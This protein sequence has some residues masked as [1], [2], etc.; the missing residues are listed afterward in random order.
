MLVYKEII[1]MK[2]RFLPIVIIFVILINLF[3]TS[4]VFAAQPPQTISEA[5]ILIDQ[6]TGRV[7]Y[8]KNAD[9]RL[10]PA[11]TTKIMTAILALENLQLDSV[12][13]ASYDAVM[14][15]PVGGS[16]MGILEGEQLTVEELLYGALVAS[17]NEACNVLAEYMC[18]DVDS[19]V[20]RMNE[21]AAELGMVNTKFLNPHGLHS[22]EHYT[23]ARDMAILARYAMQN[24]KFR[25]MV[26]TPQYFIEP[27][28]KYSQKRILTS[29][30]HLISRIQNGSYY[31]SKA[32]GIKTGYTSQAGNCLVSSASKTGTNFIAVTLNAK[33]QSDAIYSFIDSKALFEYGFT[34][35]ETRSLAKPGELIAEAKVKEGRGKDFA[36]LEVSEEVSGLLPADADINN[37]QKTITLKENILAPIA[38]GD[39]LGEVAY[40]Y[41][42]YEL[43][44]AALVS[45]VEVKRDF[46]IFIM[47]RIFGFFNLLWVKIPLIIIIAFILY[48]IISRKLKRRK[49]RKYLRSRRY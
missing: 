20:V 16:N 6:G 4:A 38:V 35:Y 32:T 33:P 46:F 39:V 24:E 48:N 37:V 18:G 11:S 27:T 3:C 34:N 44:R 25:I 40:T 15:I 36:T 43:G 28:N 12:A 26:S 5:V 47:N 9:K 29:T 2:K 14:S 7:L 17:A 42:G 19:F 31:Y 13:V 45:N 10:Y 49:R 41:E 21:K 30:N 23:T 22:P 8:E 1:L